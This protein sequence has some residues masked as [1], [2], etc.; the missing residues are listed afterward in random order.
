MNTSESYVFNVSLHSSLQIQELFIY[1]HNHTHTPLPMV[2]H[3]IHSLQINS[4]MAFF[5]DPQFMS[6]VRQASLLRCLSSYLFCLMSLS[7]STC[8]LSETMALS[9]NMQWVCQGLKEEEDKWREGMRGW[10]DNGFLWWLTFQSGTS[11]QVWLS[12]CVFTDSQMKGG[13]VTGFVCGT[14]S[15]KHTLSNVHLRCQGVSVHLNTSACVSVWTEWHIH[16]FL[17]M[18]ADTR[19]DNAAGVTVRELLSSHSL[20]QPA[21]WLNRSFRLPGEIARFL[22]WISLTHLSPG[23]RRTWP[24]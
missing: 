16:L 8:A 11:Q 21:S 10:E 3:S 17:L 19:L 18:R 1:T 23:A 24:A 4:R 13:L 14:E 22:I 15:N 20:S 7:P 6:A 12:Y 2:L 9:S 5:Y